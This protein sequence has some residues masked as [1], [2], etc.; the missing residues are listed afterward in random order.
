MK[1]F[2]NLNIGTRII[3]GFLIVVIIA[4]LIGGIG[5]FSLQR[6]NSSYSISYTDSTAA[7]EYTEGIS[8]SF[9]RIR[10]NL[11]GIILAE[12][13]RDKE[14]Y[15]DRMDEFKSVIDENIANYRDMLSVYKEEEVKNEI[16]FIDSVQE[17]LIAFGGKREEMIQTVGMDPERRSEAFEWVQDGGQLRDLALAVDEAIND[18]IEYNKF[19]A[20]EQIAKNKRLALISTFSIIAGIVV[21]IIIAILIGLYIARSISGK[22]ETLVAA[23]DQL[24]LGDVGVNITAETEDE[25]GKLM[26]AFNKMVVNIRDQAMAV[27][28]IAGG[29]LTIGVA[30]KSDKDLLGQ[31]LNELIEKNNDVLLQITNAAD[32]VSVGSDQ[33]AA[34]SQALSQGAAEQAS[35]VE[36]L[37]ATIAEVSEE[38][39]NSAGLAREASQLSQEAG[40]G[41]EESNRQMEHLMKAMEEITV[42]SQEINKIIKTIEDIAFQTNILSLNAAVEAARAGSAGKGFAV[43]ADEV[44]NLAGK[45][46]EAAQN[47]TDLIESTLNAIET[48]RRLTDETANSLNQVTE[49]AKTVDEQVQLIATDIEREAGAVNQI[50]A[51]VDQISAVV[52]NNSATSEESAAASEELAGQA[53]LLKE[54]ISKYKLKGQTHAIEG[55]NHAGEGEIQLKLSGD[56][57]YGK[58]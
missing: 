22:I 36:E 53:M 43:V 9:Q 41:V 39:K 45:S 29:D 21:G 25:I 14:F 42:T 54:Q 47:T 2:N 20:Q 52:Q 34:S 40:R 8:S 17:R 19:Y 48:G 10:L 1:K 55:N 16:N 32:Q 12:T 46:A 33:V 49:K 23:S 50:A 38:L 3:V 15:I 5:I 31:K 37:T 4:G 56:V 7:L 30:V 26:V 51:G 18:L 58:Y 35:S 6:V 28:S 13:V 57:E 44:R 24:A 27:E 11:L